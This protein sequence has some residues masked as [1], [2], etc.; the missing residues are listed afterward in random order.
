MRIAC[1]VNRAEC[2]RS[3]IDDPSSTVDIEEN[4]KLLTQ[5]RRNFIGPAGDLRFRRSNRGRHV[6]AD[7]RHD[8]SWAFLSEISNETNN[9]RVWGGIHTRHACT[10]GAELGR[11]VAEYCLAN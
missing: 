8:P 4:P 3:G 6:S 10:D 11:K 7:L 1:D 5:G 9:A 2:L